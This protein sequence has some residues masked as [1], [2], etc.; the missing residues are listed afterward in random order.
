MLLPT[1]EGSGAE[2]PTISASTVCRSPTTSDT[3]RVTVWPTAS[4]A[5]SAPSDSSQEF[6][7]VSSMASDSGARPASSSREGA[8]MGKPTEGTC[9]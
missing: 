3:A 1:P 4:A 6:G 2:M 7:T 8:S 5:V 9:H